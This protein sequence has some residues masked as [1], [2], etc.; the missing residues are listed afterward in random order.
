M[1]YPKLQ[2]F[3]FLLSELSSQTRRKARIFPEPLPHFNIHFYAD[4]NLELHPTEG[5]FEVGI[6]DGYIVGIVIDG[7]LRP[8]FDQYRQRIV[9][10]MNVNRNLALTPRLAANIGFGQP[11]R[12]TV[13]AILGN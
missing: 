9:V 7:L 3:K 11:P 2:F 5:V 6:N 1:T 12:E 8:A 10:I 13:Q 4:E